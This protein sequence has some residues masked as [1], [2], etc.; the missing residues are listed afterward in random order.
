MDKLDS[1]RLL[2]FTILSLKCCD[3]TSDPLSY[4]GLSLHYFGTVYQTKY[5][6]GATDEAMLDYLKPTLTTMEVLYPGCRI[7]LIDDFNCLNISHL[8]VQ[9]KLKQLVCVT[10]RET[11]WLLI[12]LRTFHICMTKT[13]CR[14]FHHF[15]LS[16]HSVVLLAP[17]LRRTSDNTFFATYAMLWIAKPKMCCSRYYS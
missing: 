7:L 13:N 9:F 14:L 15:G 8:L 3:R 4:L 11:I 16:N 1:R 5:P 6:P 2:I 17:I 12:L 10:K